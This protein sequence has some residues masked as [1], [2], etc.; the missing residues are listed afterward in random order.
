MQQDLRDK[1]R[2]SSERDREKKA[3][4]RKTEEEI[5]KFRRQQIVSFFQPLIFK[6]LMFF[7]LSCIK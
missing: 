6:V 5:Q 7:V 4:Q 1:I 3:K 2:E